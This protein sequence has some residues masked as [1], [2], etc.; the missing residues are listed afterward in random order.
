MVNTSFVVARTPDLFWGTKRSS[1]RSCVYLIRERL[2]CR[3]AAFA[4]LNRLLAMTLADFSI[5]LSSWRNRKVTHC[6]SHSHTFSQEGHT[7]TRHSDTLQPRVTVFAPTVTQSRFLPLDRVPCVPS[8]RKSPAAA[9]AILR[10]STA[11]F[12]ATARLNAAPSS[13]IG[14]RL[15]PLP[16]LVRGGEKPY[17]KANAVG[18]D[19]I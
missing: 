12:C 3:V 7:F 17:L 11:C 4:S 16:D 1:I 2:D 18:Q 8:C 10:P 5:F 14:I 13:D 6:L 15:A 9:H 19:A